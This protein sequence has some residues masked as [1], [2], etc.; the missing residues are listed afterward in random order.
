MRLD[1]QFSTIA[2]IESRKTHE[3]GLAFSI[4][5]DLYPQRA[6]AVQHAQRRFPLMRGSQFE[7]VA[8]RPPRHASSAKWLREH[9]TT[10]KSRTAYAG[11]IVIPDCL[12]YRGVSIIRDSTFN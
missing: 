9:Y 8:T 11:R 3:V 7:A 5:L 2:A 12:I 4:R 10:P 1:G 6:T